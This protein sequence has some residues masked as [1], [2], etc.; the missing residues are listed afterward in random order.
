MASLG[1]VLCI[2]VTMLAITS[3]VRW[4]NFLPGDDL[5][6]ALSFAFPVLAGIALVPFLL[7][8]RTPRTAGDH[9]RSR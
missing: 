4:G 8:T 3:S 5:A 9:L 2:V 1:C 6:N 7:S